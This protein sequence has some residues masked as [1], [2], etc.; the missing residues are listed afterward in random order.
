LPSEWG[1]YAEYFYDDTKD[2]MAFDIAWNHHQKRN[3]H[4]WQYWFLRE[5]N[6]QTDFTAYW[7]GLQTKKE[8]V[9]HHF[10]KILPMPD[11]YR[12]EML[13]DWRGAAMV[14]GKS[15]ESTRDWYLKNKENIFLHPETQ[16]WVEEELGF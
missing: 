6:S 16:K 2:Q 10:F 11:K 8:A 7:L 13:C 15:R 3:P 1:A 12:K 4:H 9:I 5:D 14:Q